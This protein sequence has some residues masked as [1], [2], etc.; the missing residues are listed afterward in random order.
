[1]AVITL[2]VE[3]MKRLHSGLGQFCLH[4]SKEIIAQDDKDTFCF[5]ID[6]SQVDNFGEKYIYITNSKMDRYIGVDAQSDLWHCMHQEPKYFP[7]NKNSKLIMT[8]HDL[9]FLDKY[10]G[11]KRE[12]KLK[13]LQQIVNKVQGIAFIS[14]HTKKV[15]FK[16]LTIPQVPNKVIYNGVALGSEEEICPEFVKS[17][18]PFLFTIGIIGEKKNFHVLVEAMKHLPEF[19]LYICG[20]NSSDYAVKIRRLITEHNLG[21]QVYLPGEISEGE[22]KWMYTNCSSFIFPSLS[23]GFGLPVVEAMN[24]GKPLVLSNLSSLPEIGGEQAYY[25]DDF[26]PVEISQK[27]RKAI[28]EDSKSKKEALIKRALKFNWK[29]S[30]QEYLN[31]YKQVLNLKG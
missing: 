31:L 15:A 25:L 2:D 4:L 10:S 9:N 29:N 21:G 28:N 12:K 27:I 5:Y 19:D 23:E 3:K 18:R 14:E 22:K 6:K 11:M 26:S 7:R 8:I 24:F 1:M 30:A 20:N 17:E 13:R 16:N